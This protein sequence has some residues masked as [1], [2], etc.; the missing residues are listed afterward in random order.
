MKKHA[1]IATR[2]ALFFLVGA[3]LLAVASPPVRAE[4]QEAKTRQIKMASLGVQIDVP[5]G[6][7]L[8]VSERLRGTS[9]FKAYATTE[10][11][12]R[13]PASLRMRYTPAKPGKPMPPLP[14]PNTYAK[15]MLA[16]LQRVNPNTQILKAE[17]CAIGNYKGVRLEYEQVVRGLP[18]SL[19]QLNVIAP[20]GSCRFYVTYGTLK[21]FSKNDL[22]M[23]EK[24]ADTIKLTTPAK[25]DDK[26]DKK[27][28]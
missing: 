24:V 8:F 25:A 18:I 28:D 12:K 21:K 17:R 7:E 2:P 1:S 15:L 19:V 13:L 22:P 4:A 11:G 9:F 16:E 3:L 14:D 10:A 5:V 23:L 27:E 26:S 6:W 20:D